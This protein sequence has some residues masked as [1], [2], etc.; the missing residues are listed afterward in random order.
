VLDVGNVVVG[1]PVVRHQPGVGG[2]GAKHESV[3]LV[4]AKGVMR[5]S[6]YS[7]HLKGWLTPRFTVRSSKP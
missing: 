3:D 4:L 1:G 6:V 2:Y 7:R 5:R